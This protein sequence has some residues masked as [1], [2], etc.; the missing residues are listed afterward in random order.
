MKPGLNSERYTKISFP[1]RKYSP[2]QSIH[3]KKYPHYSHLPEIPSE[4]TKFEPDTWK[5]SQRYLYSIDLFN[6]GYWWEAHEVLED[7]WIKAGKTTLTAKFIQGIIQ[8]SAALLKDSQL[9]PQGASRLASKGLSKLRLRS[10]IFLGIDV[11]EFGQKVEKY[12]SGEF[13]SPPQ[14][15]L[16]GSKNERS[17]NT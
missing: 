12:F 11:Q 1:D 17:L 9:S 14:I 13:S 15:F 7:L 10:G 8:I 16:L 5:I 6:F 2:G 4:G 3:P